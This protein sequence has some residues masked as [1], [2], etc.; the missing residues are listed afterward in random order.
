M[1]LAV[2][3]VE[4]LLVFMFSYK[5]WITQRNNDPIKI[6]IQK[7]ITD[8][9]KFVN[10][11]EGIGFYSDPNLN[12]NLAVCE[13]VPVINLVTI[14]SLD[15]MLFNDTPFTGW[16]KITPLSDE[17]A[18]FSHDRLL[19]YNNR[20]KSVEIDYDCVFFLPTFITPDIA[21]DINRFV[22]SQVE[23]GKRV[24]LKVHPAKGIGLELVKT[25]SDRRILAYNLDTLDLVKKAEI[26][27]SY[28]SSV[29][30][31][32]M[33]EG[34]QVSSLTKFS[35]SPIVPTGDPS[36][37]SMDD[38]KQFLYWYKN[39]FSI[40]IHQPTDKR[41]ATRLEIAKAC[42]FNTNAIMTEEVLIHG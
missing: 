9:L 26:V 13:G 16:R 31:I 40:D 37:V 12:N 3:Q 21:N 33:I 35:L 1:V 42:N 19:K 14:Y 7:E 18:Y 32:G 22:D 5:D 17:S 29:C 38:L 36:S 34:K 41:V 39:I 20:G 6:T 30:L 8:V 2:V 15:Y 28:N 25:D 10:K 23:Q 11:Y 4:Y 27:S 24:I